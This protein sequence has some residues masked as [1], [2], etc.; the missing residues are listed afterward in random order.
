MRFD[1][2]VCML[3]DRGMPIQEVSKHLGHEDLRTTQIYVRVE[4]ER[5]KQSHKKF[6]S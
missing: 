6:M 4:Q 3:I 2:S 5:I 1:T